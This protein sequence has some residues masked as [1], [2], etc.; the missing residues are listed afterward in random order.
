MRCG[1]L[2]PFVGAAGE[3]ILSDDSDEKW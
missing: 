2:D 3:R 1:D